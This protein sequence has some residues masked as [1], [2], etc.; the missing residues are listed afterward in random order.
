MSKI[1]IMGQFPP[2]IHGL[3]KAVET[4][5]NSR[6]KEKYHFSKINITDNRLIVKNIYRLIKSKAD[7][8]YLTIGQSRLGNL[9]DLIFL[10]IMQLRRKPCIVHVH[11]G[12][13]RILVDKDLPSWQ[14]RLNYKLVRGLAGGIVLGNSLKKIFKGMIT[15]DKIFVC[16]NCV[17]NDYL[18]DSIEE[19]IKLAGN[20]KKLHVLYL[21]N[22]IASKGYREVLALA[23]KFSEERND[24]FVFHFAGK[25]YSL[26]D[27]EY[28][29]KNSK[30]LNNTIFH[31]IVK[32]KSKIDLLRLCNIFILLT[33][34]PNEGQ[35]ISILEALGNGMAVVTTNHAGIPEIVSS[36]NGFLCDK[37]N[38]D[39][40]KIYYYLM[41]CYNN[42]QQFQQICLHN[43]KEAQDKYTENQY[44][45][46][47][48]KIFET[49]CNRL[50]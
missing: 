1:C 43:F 8:I 4:L 21:S 24:K 41:D 5:Y 50:K 44:I 18:A 10:I 14:K 42:R 28:F 16:P 39:I 22:F 40:D 26:E 45:N 11:G 23:R 12:Y 30:G 6:L 9:R 31:G 34:Y 35:P 15:D 49:I 47:M 7:V 25:F 48:D 36:E 27:K 46:N 20:S 13:Y 2:P 33:N 29:E 19:K 38:I 3:S 37:N 32:G 17:D